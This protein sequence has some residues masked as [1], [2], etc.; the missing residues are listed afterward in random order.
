MS[1]SE[2]TNF[3]QFLLLDNLKAFLES[4]N[5]YNGFSQKNI[6]LSIKYNEDTIEIPFDKNLNVLLSIDQNKKGTFLNLDSIFEYS[7]EKYKGKIWYENK[8]LKLGDLIKIEIKKNIVEPPCASYFD[9][10]EKFDFDNVNEEYSYY[11]EALIAKG[12]IIE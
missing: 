11:K 12:Y 10:D 3:T 4:K 2:F 8:L 5:L 6:G 1:Y 9:L 7:D